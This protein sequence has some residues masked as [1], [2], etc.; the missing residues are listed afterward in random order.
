[1]V[2]AIRKGG[3]A[4]PGYELVAEQNGRVV[5]HVCLSGTPLHRTD[6]AVQTITMLSPLSV[7]PTRQHGGVGATLVRSVLDRAATDGVP[8]VVLEGSPNYYARFGFRPA[9]AYGITM[10]IPDWAPPEAAQLRVLD[11]GATV[12]AGRVE[13]PAYVP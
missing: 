4:L 5:G 10:P 1:M 7:D 8:F 11:P 3:F 12:P 2:R 9:A 6:G 13:Y